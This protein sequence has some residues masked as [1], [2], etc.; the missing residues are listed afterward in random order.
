MNI[1][2]FMILSII[3]N[4]S[5]D[6]ENIFRINQKY[7][8]DIVEYIKNKSYKNVKYGERAIGSLK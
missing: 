5:N 4:L 8:V 6:D 7:N 1:L 3:L 2:F